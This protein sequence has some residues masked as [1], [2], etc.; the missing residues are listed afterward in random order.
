VSDY[1]HASIT[2]GG[3]IDRSSVS[4]LIEA[5][6]LENLKTEEYR[7]VRVARPEDFLK[8]LKPDGHFSFRDDAAPWGEFQVLETFLRE[9]RIPFDRLTD[10]HAQYQGEIVYYR[11]HLKEP[12]VR[13]ADDSGLEFVEREEVESLLAIKS[14]RSLR[15]ELRRIL[16]PEVGELPPIDPRVFRRE[17]GGAS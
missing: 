15:K 2:I 4:G 14:L 16:G 3:P 8:Y 7:P 17:R 13:P 11:P 12:V 9:A 5:V 10:N 1:I 6:G